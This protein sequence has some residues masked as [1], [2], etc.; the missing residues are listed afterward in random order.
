MPRNVT[1]AGNDR[2]AAVAATGAEENRV[3]LGIEVQ[4]KDNKR[5][6]ETYALLDNGSEVT[7]CHERLAKEL[8]LDGDRLDGVA[9]W[10]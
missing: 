2:E 8:R 5:M 7:L 6:V 1:G 4:G 9:L 3:C 10:L